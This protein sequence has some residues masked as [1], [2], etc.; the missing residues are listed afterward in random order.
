MNGFHI[1]ASGAIQGHHGPLVNLFQTRNFGFFKSEG[2]ADDNFRF[3]GN[4]SKISKLVEKNVRT[5]EI[6][7]YN[8]LFP[9][10]FLL[11]PNKFLF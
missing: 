7:P 3:D 1:S 8:N 4:G 2:F 11:F 5:G 9:L 6:A 10:C